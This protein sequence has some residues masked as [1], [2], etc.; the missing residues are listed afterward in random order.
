MGE[1]VHCVCAKGL[2]LTAESWGNLEDPRS[3]AVPQ[4]PRGQVGLGDPKGLLILPV[5]K[6]LSAQVTVQ[7]GFLFP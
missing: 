1:R 7:K 6:L 5:F 4:H 2:V 3:G